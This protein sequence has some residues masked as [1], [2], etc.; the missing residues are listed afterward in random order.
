MNWNGTNAQV[1]VRMFSFEFGQRLD[2]SNVEGM[3]HTHLHTFWVSTAQVTLCCGLNRFVQM[4]VSIGAG[5]N[6]Q[7]AEKTDLP[8]YNDSRRFRV[9]FNPVTRAD[10][11]AGCGF[12]LQARAGKNFALFH[13]H[14]DK[15]IGAEP[16]LL[17]VLMKL[18]CLL[19][20]EASNAP[21]EFHVYNSHSVRFHYL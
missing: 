6:T 11:H 21:V 2:I 12:T 16:I 9:P 3:G 5:L 18:T 14:M 20:T 1:S 7:T 13:V 10:F 19:A 4:H 8:V 15:Y 17:A